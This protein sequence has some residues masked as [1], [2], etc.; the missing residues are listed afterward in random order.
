M[1]IHTLAQKIKA[2]VGERRQTVIFAGILIFTA[3]SSFYVG[4]IAHIEGGTGVSNA[5][6]LIDKEPARPTSTIPQIDSNTPVKATDG[7]YIASKNGT[8]Y[9]PKACSGVK[10]IKEANRVYFETAA[11]AEAQGYSLASGC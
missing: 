7:A 5:P 2:S 6:V 8:K 11:D 3:F 4:Y 9:Y 10:R 1:S